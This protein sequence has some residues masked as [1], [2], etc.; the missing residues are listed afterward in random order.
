M[1]KSNFFFSLWQTSY[2]GDCTDHETE[3]KYYNNFYF[4]GNIHKLSNIPVYCENDKILTEFQLNTDR[5]HLSPDP[6][7]LEWRYKY[8]CC[9]TSTAVLECT[10][11][12]TQEIQSQMEI[13]SLQHNNVECGIGELMNGFVMDAYAVDE[14]TGRHAYKLRCC[15]H[16]RSDTCAG[17]NQCI[18]PGKNLT[19][20]NYSN[21]LTNHFCLSKLLWYRSNPRVSIVDHWFLL[22]P[23]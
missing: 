21:I 17:N 14:Y 16:S 3:W 11:M 2:L 8:R 13:I 4:R 5:A 20:M 1:M 7:P 10:N 18:T 12:R 9:S 23:S 22:C 6:Y 15:Q 19:T